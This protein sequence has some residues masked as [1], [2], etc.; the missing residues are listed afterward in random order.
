M[1]INLYLS[2]CHSCLTKLD[3][4]LQFCFVC[5][6]PETD[7]GTK[8]HKLDYSG[9]MYIFSERISPLSGNDWVLA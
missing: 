2:T 8:A 7:K 1:L 6:F 5:F 3:E 4:H 9:H